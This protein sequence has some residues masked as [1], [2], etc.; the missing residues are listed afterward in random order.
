MRNLHF[1]PVVYIAAVGYIVIEGYRGL[2]MVIGG[3]TWL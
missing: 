2:Y 3:Y 1:Q